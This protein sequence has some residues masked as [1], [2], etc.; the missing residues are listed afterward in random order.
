MF[1]YCNNSRNET[2][3]A[4]LSAQNLKILQ[5]YKINLPIIMKRIQQE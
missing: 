3:E 2:K 5:I 1:N 4:N